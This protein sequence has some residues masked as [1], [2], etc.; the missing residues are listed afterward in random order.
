MA[1][2]SVAKGKV[3]KK[4]AIKK[5][6]AKSKVTKKTASKKA[7]AKKTAPKAKAVKKIAV[8][9]P[10]KLATKKVITKGPAAKKTSLK[11]QAASSAKTATSG[12]TS[13][14]KA[15]Q[16]ELSPLRDY[17][18]I[19]KQGYSEKTPGGLYIPATA[20]EKPLQGEV[21]GLGQGALNKKGQRK[22]LDVSIGDLVI[23]RNFSG[24]DIALNGEDYLLIREEDILGISGK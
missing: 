14:M 4:S 21:V 8:K 1:K 11:P 23:Y 3:A 18:L 19:K 24:T 7:A 17:V 2:K 15:L 13:L 6:V 22:P 20:Q 5:T 16:T 12:Q 10:K 9:P